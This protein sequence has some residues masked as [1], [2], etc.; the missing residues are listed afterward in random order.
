M[1]NISVNESDGSVIVNL[2]R[3]GNHSDNITVCI[4][5]TTVVDP[6]IAQRMYK[7]CIA[8]TYV[9]CTAAFAP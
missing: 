7:L 4:D 9:R 6:A 5:V 8:C 2:I 3:T 1:P